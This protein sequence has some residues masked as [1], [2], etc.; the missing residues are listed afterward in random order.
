[1]IGVRELSRNYQKGLEFYDQGLL[2]D[3]LAS[4]EAV[5]KEADPNNPEAKLA[6]FYIGESHAR[7]AEESAGRGSIERAIEHLQSALKRN[8][9]FPDLH[10]KLASLMA[11]A[12]DTQGAMMQLESALELNPNYARALL[13]LGILAYDIGEH[14]AALEHISQAVKTEPRFNVPIYQNALNAHNSGKFDEAKALF[15]ELSEENIDD[16]SYHVNLGKKLYRSGDY[17]HA[18]EA[19]EQAL[20][21]QNNYPDIRNWFGLS[22]MACKEN[23]RAFEQFQKALEINPEYIGALINAGIAC[24][25]MDLKADSAKFYK[26]ALEID[27]ENIEARERLSKI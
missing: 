14:K 16:I 26:H 9:N 15:K 1:M 25:L 8:P 23:E 21:L 24:D 10:Y 17:K 20:S 11:N 22:L 12:G 18:V 13:L 27:P 4:F 19:F 6:K 2:L 7:L 3:A 5:L